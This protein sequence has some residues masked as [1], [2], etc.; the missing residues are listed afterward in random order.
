MN[1]VMPET[2]SNV[3]APRGLSWTHPLGA[4]LLAGAFF[5]GV[6]I[7]AV[8]VFSSSPIPNSQTAAA[9]S[10][11]P[12]MFDDL[13]IE[14]KSAV[15]FDLEKGRIL[16]E[17]NPDVQLP[18]AS[19]TK[20]ALT[21]VAAESLQMDGIVLSP[22]NITS[23]DGKLVLPGGALWRVE[24]VIDAT[25]I[26]SSNNGAEF[27]A[28]IAEESVRARYPEAPSENATLWRMNALVKELSLESTY[29]LNVTGLDV[30][31]SLAG[32]YGSARDM[33]ILFTRAAT[34]NSRLFEAT[35]RRQA[36]FT[37]ADGLYG[38]SAQNTNEIEGVIP[39]LIMGKTGFTDLAGG[40]L[41]IVFDIG[42]SRPVV[43]IV[44]GSSLDGRFRDMEKLVDASREA[45]AAE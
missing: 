28:S 15:V 8:H 16:Y 45:I 43:I 34:S 22:Y 24:D 21:L 19:L 35:A 10:T 26:S 23:A 5:A 44:L 2:T 11:L 4:A 9:A 36:H 33:G 29:F 39:N 32:A 13:Q 40:N 18:L 31:S 7:I 37:S 14:A 3:G 25:L 38:A 12:S 20:A 27:L 17:K 42:I 30:S 6:V 41:A 1:Q